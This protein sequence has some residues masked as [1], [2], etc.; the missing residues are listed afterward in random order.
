[1]GLKS[2]AIAPL[3]LRLFSPKSAA[4]RFGSREVIESSFT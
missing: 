2:L 1:L 4:L 3:F